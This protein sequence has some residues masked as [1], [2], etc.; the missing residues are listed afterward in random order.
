M[1]VYYSHKH[2]AATQVSDKRLTSSIRK[3]NIILS[4]PSST[5]IF[6]KCTVLW[7]FLKVH[8]TNRWAI[9]DSLKKLKQN[10]MIEFIRVIFY[11]SK[12]HYTVSFWKH[13]GNWTLYVE[14]WKFITIS[15]R[16]YFSSWCE[17][18]TGFNFKHTYWWD[19]DIAWFCENTISYTVSSIIITFCI[20]FIHSRFVFV[21][22]SRWLGKGK[23]LLLLPK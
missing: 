3:H 18:K 8:Y 14:N 20:V 2:H 17:L 19:G 13:G 11:S 10:R 21:M 7:L 1:S 6:K 15:G 22:L 9:G 5:L 12:K 23:L 4:P 16:I